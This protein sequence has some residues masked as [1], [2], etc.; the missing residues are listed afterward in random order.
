[1]NLSIYLKRSLLASFFLVGYDGWTEE[2]AISFSGLAYQEQVQLSSLFHFQEGRP[3]ITDQ[4]FILS[5][6]EASIEQEFRLNIAAYIDKEGRQEYLCHFPARSLWFSR[7]LRQPS[8]TFEHCEGLQTYLDSVP[9]DEVS[10][11]YASENIVS[12]SSFMGHSFLKMKDAEDKLAHA[13]SY[14][15]EV[16]GFNLPKIMFE[17]LVTGKEGYFIISPYEEARRYYKDIEGRNVYEY[18]LALNEFDKEFIRLHMWELKDKNI[19]YYFHTNNCAT[20]TLDILSL[21]EPSLNK[22]S[23]EWLSPL[24]IIKYVSEADMVKSIQVSPSVGWRVRAFGDS[25]SYQEKQNVFIALAG[26]KQ[27]SRISS[28]FQGAEEQYLFHEYQKALN[29][30]LYFDG[31]IDYR[32]YEHNRMRL[33]LEREIVGD[34]MMDL[35]TY[36]NPL[37]RSADAQIIFGSRLQKEGSHLLI[38]W[39]PASHM[40]TDDNRNALSESSLEV[41]KFT[42]GIKGNDIYLDEMTLYGIES[43]IPY[44]EIVGGVSGRFKLGWERGG[45]ESYQR[46]RRFRVSAALGAALDIGSSV[47]PYASVGSDLSMNSHAVW[48]SPQVDI[49]AFLYLANGSK[50]QVKYW[51]SFN[52]LRQSE[53][54]QGS[55]VLNSY[56]IGHNAAIDVGFSHT[57][58]E[59]FDESQLI[60]N[61]RKF[62]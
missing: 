29:D 55:A 21:A 52:E 62:Y 48:M 28:F 1:M 53:L 38:S 42:A 46:N 30:W 19:D 59:N 13:V 41:M 37:N 51:L 61:I 4:S 40:V 12:P 57:L 22:H 50:L 35:S 24:D 43:Y 20:L 3:R 36:K 49:G 7:Y 44:D 8:P 2:A 9:A 10:L 47:L 26:K 17:S 31:A 58:G 6:K 15:T 25:F 45:Y 32:Q 54:T 39:L 23:K 27:D 56:Y 60:F 11:V 18:D 16:D 5:G 34:Y 14:F 33:E